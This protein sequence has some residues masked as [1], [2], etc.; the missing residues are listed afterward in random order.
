MYMYIYNKYVFKY[1][2][3]IYNVI[4]NIIYDKYVITI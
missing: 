1:I 3:N 4:C 2:Q